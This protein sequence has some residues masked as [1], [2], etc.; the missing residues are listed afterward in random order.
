MSS[1][2]LCAV[3]RGKLLLC[4]LEPNFTPH[5]RFHDSWMPLMH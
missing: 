3:G 4:L 2:Q 1:G 5:S